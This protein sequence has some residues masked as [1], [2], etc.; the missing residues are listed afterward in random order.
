MERTSKFSLQ[1]A[2]KNS[3]LVI[4]P[5]GI[6]AFVIWFTYGHLG[7]QVALFLAIVF[8]I[9]LF[10]PALIWISVASGLY[11]VVRD[12]IRRRVNVSR[13]KTLKRAGELSPRESE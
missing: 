5:L 8:P 7:W 13:R 1:K 2:I 12:R 11:D 9:I 4:V 10:I 6:Y 3:V